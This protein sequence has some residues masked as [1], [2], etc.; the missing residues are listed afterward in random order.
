MKQLDLIDTSK[1]LIMVG[2]YSTGKECV[3]LAI[4]KVLA[5]CIARPVY[6]SH[7]LFFLPSFL[8]FEVLTHM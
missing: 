6:R 2:S 4:T 5:I 3:C 7:S 8:D 1:T